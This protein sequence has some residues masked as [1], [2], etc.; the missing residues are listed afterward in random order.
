MPDRRGPR[1]ASPASQPGKPARQAARK[2]TDA[3]VGIQ[4]SKNLVRVES[5]PA[6]AA[7]DG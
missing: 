2:L 7:R 5:P 4:L 1:Q 6:R 3:A